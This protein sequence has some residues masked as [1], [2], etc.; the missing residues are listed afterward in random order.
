MSD[1]WTNAYPDPAILHREVDAMAEAI[2]EVLLEAVPNDEIA[3]IYMKG[4]GHKHWDSPLDYVPELSDVDVHLHFHNDDDMDRRVGCLE[5]ALELQERLE[6]AFHAKA[7]A[8]LHYPRPQLTNVNELRRWL[9]YVPSPR[10]TVKTLYGEPYPI[11][12]YSDPV[13][14]RELDRQRLLEQAEPLA[15][16]PY[17]AVDKPGP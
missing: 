14:L 1:S 3:G 16:L 12:D 17:Q 2:V 10:T 11:G 8:P 15:K 6:R 7:P 9:D 13:R 5:T 4:S